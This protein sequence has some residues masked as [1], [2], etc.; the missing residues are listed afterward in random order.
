MRSDPPGSNPLRHHEPRS[1][2][3]HPDSRKSAI[4]RG[5]SPGRHVSGFAGAWSKPVRRSRPVG[6]RAEFH[7]RSR[8]PR[9]GDRGMFGGFRG[10]E[11]ALNTSRIAGWN[12]PVLLSEPSARVA[13]GEI[14]RVSSSLF[15]QPRGSPLEIVCGSVIVWCVL[16]S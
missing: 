6:Q 7:S 1:G 9:T 10:G 12:A 11:L 4:L 5:V 13:A 8:T 15:K 14:Q 3:K 2:S 16:W